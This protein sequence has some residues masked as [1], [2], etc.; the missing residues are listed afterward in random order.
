[1]SS[2][3][4]KLTPK[5][6]AFCHE[7]VKN[8]FNA[9]SAALAVG[10]SEK[11]AYSQ[12]SRLLTKVEVL[13]K[14]QS[15]K[16][17]IL[18]KIQVSTEEVLSVVKELAFFDARL[19]FDEYSRLLPVKDWPDE[20]ARCVAQVDNF[21]EYGRDEDGNKY[22]IGVVRRVKFWNKP[23]AIEMLMKYLGLF[24]KDNQQRPTNIYNIEKV[25]IAFVSPNGQNGNGGIP[26]KT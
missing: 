26:G 3:G 11:T 19:A 15:L 10:F 24:E 5:Q 7:Y 13:K 16:D 20:V 4:D 12:A 21:E 14:I 1:M 23:Q 9:T 22:P 25:Q 17:K 6:E 2:K 18:N 8:S